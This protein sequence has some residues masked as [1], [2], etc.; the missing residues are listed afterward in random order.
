MGFPLPPNLQK[1]KEMAEKSGKEL[2]IF[3]PKGGIPVLYGQ[4]LIERLNAKE[5]KDTKKSRFWRF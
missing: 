2:R 1:E 5:K 3:M 4:D